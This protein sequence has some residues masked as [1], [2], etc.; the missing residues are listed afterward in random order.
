[1]KQEF[2]FFIDVGANIVFIRF[3]GMVTMVELVKCYSEFV[4]HPDFKKDMG[5]CYDL[6][7]ALLEVGINEIEIITQY[8]TGMRDK[9][10]T[11]YKVAF[12]CTDDMAQVLSKL[13]RL[14]LVRTDIE[15]ELFEDK[16]DAIIWLKEP[17]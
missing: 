2:D 13:Y 7:E 3:S 4:R 1:M 16:K 11:S 6:S 17:I 12:V 5:C 9:R 10:G 15:V 8:V 14:S